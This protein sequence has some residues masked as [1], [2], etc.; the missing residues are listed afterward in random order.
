MQL[1]ALALTDS[2]LGRLAIG[3]TDRGVAMLQILDSAG[4]LPF[5]QNQPAQDHI[6]RAVDQ[7]G[8]YFAGERDN[9]DLSLDLA[10]TDFQRAVWSA[11]AEVGKS[12][13]VSYGELA[14]A[15]GRPLAARAVGGAVGANP[16][17]IILGCHRVLGSGRTLTGYSATGGLKTKQWL[18]EFEGI[19][20]KR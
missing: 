20:F 5:K 16:V 1:S 4:P 15:A 19:E 7:L 12:Q 3:A 6:D 9:F 8:Q 11:L 14:L 2:L 10:G 13:S 18:L 17:P